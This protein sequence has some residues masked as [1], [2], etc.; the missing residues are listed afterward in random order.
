MSK[1]LRIPGR[2]ARRDECGELRKPLFFISRF[3][4]EVKWPTHKSTSSTQ[5]TETSTS[6]ACSL[7]PGTNPDQ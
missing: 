2:V 4:T 1:S 6:T 7:L 3:T 5:T